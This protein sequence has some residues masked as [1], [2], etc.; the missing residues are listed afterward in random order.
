MIVFIRLALWLHLLS[1]SPVQHQ[2]PH[3]PPCSNFTTPGT[4]IIMPAPASYYRPGSTSTGRLG[5]AVRVEVCE[6]R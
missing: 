3:L 4:V 5:I 2:S 6:E 1:T